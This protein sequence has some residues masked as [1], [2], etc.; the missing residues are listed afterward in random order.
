MKLFVLAIFNFN[1]FHLQPSVAPVSRNYQEMRE[2]LRLLLTKK[3]LKCKAAA[4]TASNGSNGSAVSS[5][6]STNGGETM[7]GL[8]RRTGG[9]LPTNGV[10][11]YPGKT[12]ATKKMQGAS[13]PSVVK[14]LSGSKIESLSGLNIRSTSSMPDIAD[15][16][17]I[18]SVLKFIEGNGSN[19]RRDAKKAAKKARQK[20]KKVIISYY[21]FQLIITQVDKSRSKIP[22]RKPKN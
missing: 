1:L 11:P 8:G 6:S 12:T 18:D 20:Q 4:A 16:D 5:T 13:G 22:W 7:A 19:S 21:L 15:P 17:D 9:R 3:K 2:R 14:S 10:P